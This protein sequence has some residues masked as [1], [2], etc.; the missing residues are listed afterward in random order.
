[1]EDN[2]RPMRLYRHKKKIY[3]KNVNG[4]KHLVNVHDGMSNVS[5]SAGKDLYNINI[6]YGPRKQI[7]GRAKKK[8][9]EIPLLTLPITE[10]SEPIVVQK[11]QKQTLGS[12]PIEKPIPTFVSK[13]AI[14]ELSEV[15]NT[16]REKVKEEVQTDHPTPSGIDDDDVPELVE[17]IKP[18]IL[19]SPQKRREEWIRPE[20]SHFTEPTEYD[21]ERGVEQYDR[22]EE[23][24]SQE[25]PTT[26]K[27]ELQEPE[28]QEPEMQKPNE[29]MH[30]LLYRPLSID[31]MRSYLNDIDVNEEN[32]KEP[33]KIKSLQDIINHVHSMNLKDIKNELRLIHVKDRDF[34]GISTMTREIASQTL[35]KY[36]FKE[37]QKKQVGSGKKKIKCVLSNI[38]I[39]NIFKK[40]DGKIVPVIPSDMIVSLLP[41]VNQKTKQFYFVM[42]VAPHK[43]N[44]RKDGH[45]IAWCLD[46]ERKTLYF[47]NSLAKPAKS[48]WLKDV[49][50]LILK[51][52]P[53][54]IWKYKYNTVRNQ[55]FN[56]SDCGYFASHFIHTMME[57][58]SFSKASFYDHPSM[59]AEKE[60]K[61]FIKKWGYI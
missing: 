23:P 11:Y 20:I 42:N 59:K 51:M 45:W 28:M 48:R 37:Q 36:L 33:E 13:N 18:P 43:S 30:N 38:D 31:Q 16:I 21:E 6:M 8:K 24:Y 7:R 19:N 40:Y 22:Q 35:I 56:T 1:M 3:Y 17:H 25:E 46:N 47:Y 58:G 60:L 27:L 41:Q 44:G 32:E 50:K 12:V 29:E 49:K 14:K 53:V 2:E 9:P 61:P 26:K 5:G 34:R 4:G 15:P 55:S 10:N 54:H 39:E 52:D 57:G